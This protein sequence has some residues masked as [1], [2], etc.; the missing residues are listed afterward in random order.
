MNVDFRY[1]GFDCSIIF[2][3]LRWE[4]GKADSGTLSAVWDDEKVRE[5]LDD[6]A[7]MEINDILEKRYRTSNRR[8]M[9]KAFKE[10]F[11]K[12]EIREIF[13]SAFG[14]LKDLV[15][16]EAESIPNIDLIPGRDVRI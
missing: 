10:E 13:Q 8:W 1:K 6:F 12:D 15:R 3:V 16:K 4:P 11:N 2:G 9:A 7:L 14:R 5:L